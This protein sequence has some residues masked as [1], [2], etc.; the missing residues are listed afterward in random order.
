MEGRGGVWQQ[1]EGHGERKTE[2]KGMGHWRDR[3]GGWIGGRP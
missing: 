2:R 3:Q 1:E